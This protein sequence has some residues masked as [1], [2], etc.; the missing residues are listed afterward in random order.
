MKMNNLIA[1]LQRVH[2][3][4]GDEPP[5]IAGDLYHELGVWIARLRE[6]SGKSPLQAS[7]PIVLAL[8]KCDDDDELY[9][10]ALELFRQLASDE[11]DEAARCATTALLADMLQLPDSTFTFDGD[12]PGVNEFTR[13]KMAEPERGTEAVR[14]MAADEQGETS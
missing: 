11:L 6:E 2:T 5:A 1:F 9:A 8:A 14:R 10:E 4:L 13:A 12:F 3:H 7:A